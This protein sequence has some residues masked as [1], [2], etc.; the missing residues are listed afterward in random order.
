MAAVNRRLLVTAL[1]L[2]LLAAV[3][4]SFGGATI[5]QAFRGPRP[6]SEQDLLALKEPPAG[7]NYVSLRLAQP[8]VD[9]GVTYG[10]KNNPGT[11]YLVLLV[12]DRLMLC[13]ARMSASGTEFTGRLQTISGVDEQAWEK[14]QRLYAQ[15]DP[16]PPPLRPRLPIMLQSVRSI[17]FDA[18][19]W[20]AAIAALAGPGVWVL[21]RWLT[22]RGNPLRHPVMKALAKHGDPAAIRDELDEELDGEGVLRIGRLTL[23][24]GWLVSVSFWSLEAARLGDVVWVYK[25]VV[26]GQGAS[27]SAVI[28][29]RDRTQLAVTGKDAEVNQM[30]RAIKAHSPWL[31]AGYG[32]ELAALWHKAPDRFL[33]VVEQAKAEYLANP[34]PGEGPQEAGEPG[35]RDGA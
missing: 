21:A 8:A 20:L 31:P 1:L 33:A 13:S 10:K 7:D 16:K 17:W 26:Q 18:C 34:P 29:L 23:T 3:P 24:P 2:L 30:L 25:R 9:T 27:I 19:A 22:V 12:G 15:R 28:S 5:V 32:P 11:K 14:F 4:A 35:P 6:V